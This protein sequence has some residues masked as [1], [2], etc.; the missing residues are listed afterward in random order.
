[1]AES[2]SKIDQ[3]VSRKVQPRR[4]NTVGTIELNAFANKN[5]GLGIEFR[6]DSPALEVQID[7]KVAFKHLTIHSSDDVRFERPVSANSSRHDSARRETPNPD[8]A[9]K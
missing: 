5:N 3:F 9:R 4:L 1:M 7:K 6:E 2:S 8:S